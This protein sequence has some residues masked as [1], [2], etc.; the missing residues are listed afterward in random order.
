MEEHVYPKEEIIIGYMHKNQERWIVHP[1]I[2]ELKE[3]AK[4]QFRSNAFHTKF[5]VLTDSLIRGLW[6]LWVPAEYYPEVG[7]GLSNMEYAPMAALMGRCTFASEV[8]N[9]SAPDTGNMEV[10][11]RFG[12]QKQKDTVR[13]AYSINII[14]TCQFSG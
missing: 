1:E 4:K 3:L 10:L 13:H 6:N 2:E 7:A 9:C 14:S 12:S 5:I 11:L 8:F